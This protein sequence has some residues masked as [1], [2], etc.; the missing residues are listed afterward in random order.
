MTLLAGTLHW[1]QTCDKTEVVRAILPSRSLALLIAI[2]FTDLV[3]TAWLH[4]QGLIV[5]L[6]PIMRG[7]IDHG[8]WLFILV[9][10]GTLALAW[11][12][13]ANYAKTNRAFVRKVCLTG[14]AEYLFVW[15]AWFVATL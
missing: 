4:A 7:F 10:G 13:M 8:E 1:P 6:N 5:E 12:T 3:L 9:K 15:I 11:Y 2:G 14:S